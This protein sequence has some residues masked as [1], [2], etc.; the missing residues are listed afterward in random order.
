MSI[1]KF[2]LEDRRILQIGFGSVGSA[3]PQMYEKHIIFKPKNIIIIDMNK[4]ILPSS[5]LSSFEFI[6]LK[7][8]RENYKKVLKKYLR[9][10]DFLVDLAWYIDTLSLIKWCYENDV[11]FLNTAVEEWEDKM[12]KNENDPRDFSLYTRQTHIRNVTK[13]WEKNSSTAILTCGANPGWVSLNFKVG[14]KD[15]LEYLSKKHPR[16][17]IVKECLD[18]L[19]DYDVPE[20]EKWPAICYLM[21]IQ[22]IHIAEKDTQISNIPKQTNEFINTWSVEGLIEEGMAPA[23]MGWGTHETLKEGVYKYSE[24]PKNQVCLNTRGINTLVKSFVPSGDITGMVIRHEE[25]YSISE[26]L[27]YKK[28]GKVKYRPTVHYA[29]QP[30]GDCLASIYEYQSRGY[31]KQE[32][33]R[34]LKNEVISGDDELGCFMLSKKYGGWWV[35]SV[36]STEQSRKMINDQSATTLQIVAGVIGGM[37]YALK[38]PNRGLIHPESIDEKEIMPIIMKYL[39]DFVSFPVKNWNPSRPSK[40]GTSKYKSKKDW[41]I[42]KLLV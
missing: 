32:K 34:I 21:E 29:Y 26:Y 1:E 33:E 40:Y 27:T 28:N 25:A 18:I 11:L 2:N 6:N 13:K 39:G 41:I 35:G 14:I 4:D 30:C 20:K 5:A 8:T 24:G 9:P 37:L 17:L 16:D 36:L 3:M 42:Q 10:G 7:V 23:E 38:H 31:K 19:Y 12:S 15:W 22:V